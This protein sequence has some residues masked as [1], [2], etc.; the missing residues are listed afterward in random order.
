MF[1]DR[2][3]LKKLT[4]CF[5]IYFLFS[6]CS[7]ASN[8]N[9]LEKNCYYNFDYQSTIQNCTNLIKIN[10]NNS[11]AYFSRGRANLL[12]NNYPSAII[13]FT[14]AINLNPNYIAAYSL[15]ANAKNN[16][17][18]FR[19][20]IIDYTQAI[21]LNP[22]EANFYWNRGDSKLGLDDFRG[23]LEDFQ[24]V[25]ALDPNRFLVLKD[26]GYAKYRLKEYSNAI[27]IFDIVIS[28]LQNEIAKPLIFSNPNLDEETKQALIAMDSSFK[29]IDKENLAEALF[30][31][32]LCKI[33][34]QFK[35]EGCIDLSTAGQ[36][37]YTK[38]YQIIKE[39]CD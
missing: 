30:F 33:I 18:D 25:L 20:A 28:Y 13:D 26:I 32:G 35:D 15:R 6:F 9:V 24:Q 37:G 1:S 12:V 39:S 31:R 27:E 17:K 8:T 4:F 36:L 23:A 29:N 38:A 2:F 11:K 16:L 14:Q 7:Y 5:I 10:N 34:L 21:G 22:K 3:T 19:G